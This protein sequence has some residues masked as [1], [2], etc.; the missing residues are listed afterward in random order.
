MAITNE[1][2]AEFLDMHKRGELTTE[3]LFDIQRE[4]DMEEQE[5]EWREVQRKRRSTIV[6][7]GDYWLELDPGWQHVYAKW[8]PEY[9]RQVEQFL[10][11]I[12]PYFKGHTLIEMDG[13]NPGGLCAKGIQL[14]DGEVFFHVYPAWGDI[15]AV[16]LI[17]NRSK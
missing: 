8:T 16:L 14:F 10:A 12:T 13:T 17:I 7:D 2:Y 4:M 11:E 1:E 6:I 9:T 15:L 5:Q 3:E